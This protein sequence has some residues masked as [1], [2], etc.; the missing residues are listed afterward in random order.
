MNLLLVEFDNDAA[1]SVATVASRMHQST[2]G[3]YRGFVKN[4]TPLLCIFNH[5]TWSHYL[6]I[7]PCKAAAPPEQTPLL[8]AAGSEAAA[9]TLLIRCYQG[10]F[11]KGGFMVTYSIGLH[12]S[13]CIP[14]SESARW[15][16]LWNTRFRFPLIATL[17]FNNS[18]KTYSL[19]RPLCKCQS[20]K[21]RHVCHSKH[22][23][24][25]HYWCTIDIIM[26]VLI[27]QSHNLDKPKGSG[28]ERNR[29]RFRMIKLVHK[30]VN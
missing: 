13:V 4:Q 6:A 2:D 27:T 11:V 28:D 29:D 23:F 5:T 21:I 18:N 9:W 17:L 8:M 12:S 25:E 19:Q 10:L 7:A 16:Y 3:S 24:Y 14:V 26:S 15:Q 1:N 30:H 20:A 22:N